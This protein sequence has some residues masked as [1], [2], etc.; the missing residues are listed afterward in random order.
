MLG[1]RLKKIFESSDRETCYALAEAVSFLKNVSTTKFDETLEV[2][3]N[4]NIDP[5]KADQNVRGMVTMPH[6][7][8]KA[9]RVAVFCKGVKIEEALAAGADIAGA[10]DL[11]AKVQ[12]GIDFDVCIATPDM[13]GIVG[14]LG[15]I[16]GPKGLMP[17]PKLGTVTMDI[18]G[19][20]KSAKSGQVEFRTEKAGIIHAGLCKLSF[21]QEKIEES[22]KA[23]VGAVVRARPAGIKGSYIKKVSLSTTMGPGLK[24]D[25]GEVYSF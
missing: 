1:K 14:R 23:F 13:M 7:T 21:S 3:I 10:E 20:V 24:L 5:R 4:L 11:S 18:A 17:N 25:L 8:G 16:L 6:G 22:I 9:V 12:E 15:K 19:A 2:A